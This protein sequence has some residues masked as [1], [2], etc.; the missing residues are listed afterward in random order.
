MSRK[1]FRLPDFAFQRG[2]QK[3][4]D[5]RDKTKQC[6]IAILGVRWKVASVLRFRAATSEPETPFF[7]GISG[8]LAQ[9]TRKSLAIAIVRFWCAKCMKE[10]KLSFPATWFTRFGHTTR[11]PQ[12]QERYRTWNCGKFQFRCIEKL[13]A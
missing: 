12:H 10:E 11:P 1:R 6:C 8:E 4:R 5:F 13:L 2:P 3:S 9:S 7:C